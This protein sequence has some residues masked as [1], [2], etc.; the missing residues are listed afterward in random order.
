MFT[1]IKATFIYKVSAV[2]LNNIDNILISVILGTVFVGYYSNYYLIVTYITSFVGIFINGIKASIG[3][4]NAEENTEKSYDTFQ[5]LILIFNFISTV[6][7]CCFLNCMQQF[8]QIWIG[9]ENVMPFLWVLVIVV[10]NYQ[11]ELMSP[12]WM[13]RETLGFFKQVQ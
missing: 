3:N 7:A 4:L 11:S 9:Q 13:F 6:I 5:Q 2:I 10:K 1:D 8:I 12:I